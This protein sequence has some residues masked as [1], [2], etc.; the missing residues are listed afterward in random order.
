[1]MQYAYATDGDLLYYHHSLWQE[2]HSRTCTELSLWWWTPCYTPQWSKKHQSPSNEWCL[3]Q[4]WIG[5]NPATHHQR[6]AT[7][8]TALPTQKMGDVLTSRHRGSRKMIDNVHFLML[9]CA[10]NYHSLPPST[11]Y[12]RHE[13]EKKGDYD[14]CFREVEHGCFLPLVLSASGGGPTAKMA[15]K[16]LASVV[17][18][19]HNQS[20]SQQLTS[21]GAGLASPYFAPWLCA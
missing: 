16:K 1:M 15:Y 17:A 8:C 3:S 12:R 6:E 2:F 19:K 5:T 4:C 18:T 10:H 20:Y 13:Q 9:G 7:P 11:C 21:S 14:Q